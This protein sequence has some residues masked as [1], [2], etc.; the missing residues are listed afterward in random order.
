MAEGIS[1]AAPDEKTG[2][3]S[4]LSAEERRAGAKAGQEERPSAEE[5]KAQPEKEG[6]KPAEVVLKGQFEAVLRSGKSSAE[7]EAEISRIVQ[8]SGASGEA[9]ESLQQNARISVVMEDAVDGLLSGGALNRK[10][11][12]TNIFNRL[13][14]A[15]EKGLLGY[16]N[17]K[18]KAL[19][20]ID[21]ELAKGVTESVAEMRTY[22]ARVKESIDADEYETTGETTIS[23]PEM[24]AVPAGAGMP[25]KSAAHEEAQK[26][27]A[28]G[29]ESVAMGRLDYLL[30]TNNFGEALE[31]VLDAKRRKSES[32]GAMEH[33]LIDSFNKYLES[34]GSTISV[35]DLA[36]LRE[37][38]VGDLH[39]QA[40]T[41]KTEDEKK[42]LDASNFL[43]FGKDLAGGRFISAY[44][45]LKSAK[46]S[47]SLNVRAMQRRFVQQVRE[48]L[49]DEAT[50]ESLKSVLRQY[51]SEIS[52]EYGAPIGEKPKT[53]ELAS[54]DLRKSLNDIFVDPSTPASIIMLLGKFGE[55]STMTGETPEKIKKAEETLRKTRKTRLAELR[56]AIYDTKT[57]IHI[58]P[59]LQRLE[60]ELLIRFATDEGAPEERST[61]SSESMNAMRQEFLPGLLDKALA[62]KNYD[63]I[64]FY[65][66]EAK[67]MKLPEYD[68]MKRK[69][70][71]LVDN[72][73]KSPDIKL[74]EEKVKRL[75]E[76]KKYILKEIFDK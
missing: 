35:P 51:E 18:E 30:K 75:E 22:L 48:T 6:Q 28:E 37:E 41:K 13:A 11:G 66:N 9:V 43:D 16:A 76:V 55:L 67:E 40:K 34:A 45:R 56:Q 71:I 54:S 65:L 14:Y 19:K 12:I 50:P 59:V 21:S 1:M 7:K 47:D 8:E 49:A 17:A 63:Q 3:H 61:S 15:K 53:S 26:Y 64:P 2:K 60:A 25:E 42:R 44:E 27:F 68:R 33:E 24:P 31:A 10:D 73:L 69:A 23:Q 52:G 70:W 74:Y 4:I 20:A 5:K 36:T 58:V 62:Q 57:P 39:E 38:I 29:Q 46:S 72:A 32:A